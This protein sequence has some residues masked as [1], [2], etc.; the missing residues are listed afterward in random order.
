MDRL[1]FWQAVIVALLSGG[2]TVLGIIVTA[3]ITARTESR[4]LQHQADLEKA[5][6]AHE[7][8][9]EEAQRVHERLL[10][11]HKELKKLYLDYYRAYQHLGV[12][13]D[14]DQ[15]MRNLVAFSDEIQLTAPPSVAEAVA[16][17]SSVVLRFIERKQ[18][19]D[20][21]SLKDLLDPEQIRATSQ[22]ELDVGTAEHLF[23]RAIRH[24]LEADKSLS[25]PVSP[26]DESTKQMLEERSTFFRK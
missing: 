23:L 16:S 18:T 19:I 26:L 8:E 9:R 15:V 20:K 25:G 24:D 22:L 11:K 1:A 14:R 10:E 7:G 21:G 12:A 2:L 13:E 17:L 6:Q 4:R 5:R 3:F